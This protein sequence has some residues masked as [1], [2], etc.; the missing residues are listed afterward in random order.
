VLSVVVPQS[1]LLKQLF[2]LLHLVNLARLKLAYHVVIM[3]QFS[4]KVWATVG[5]R[6]LNV[7]LWDLGHLISVLG[8]V[9]IVQLVDHSLTGQGTISFFCQLSI[10]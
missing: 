3:L 5:Q 10:R 2:C 8:G 4:V 6:G 1:L 7:H 9:K